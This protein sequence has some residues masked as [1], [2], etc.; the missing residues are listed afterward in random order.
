L[1]L[2]ATTVAAQNQVLTQD[3]IAVGVLKMSLDMS[4]EQGAALVKMMDQA[5][6]LG[7]RVDLHG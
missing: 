5:G 3:K 4:A 7:Q 1:E 2:T 6:G